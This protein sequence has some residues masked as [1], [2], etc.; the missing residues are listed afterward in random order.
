[1]GFAYALS[2]LL[3]SGLWPCSICTAGMVPIP[4]LATLH[5]PDPGAEQA[6]SYTGRV[7]PGRPQES[8]WHCA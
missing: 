5:K 8:L 3:P 2:I 1:M 7:C 6:E 4:W